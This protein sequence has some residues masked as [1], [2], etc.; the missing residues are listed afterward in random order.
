MFLF[1]S[2]YLEIDKDQNPFEAFNSYTGL[3]DGAITYL[4][5]S[6]N[7]TDLYLQKTKCAYCLIYCR[8]IRPSRCDNY[9]D[10]G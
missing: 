5:R 8:T 6:E 7:N 3:K 4:F 1:A 9:S 2:N 10:T